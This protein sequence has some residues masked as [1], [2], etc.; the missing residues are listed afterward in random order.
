MLHIKT[1]EGWKQI[2]STRLNYT[3]PRLTYNEKF[4]KAHKQEVEK[5]ESDLAKATTETKRR[6]VRL[7]LA[8]I[9]KLHNDA[10]KRHEGNHFMPE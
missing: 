5:L 1:A 10:V 3:F 4:G 7:D 2:E 9:K 8:F 6:S